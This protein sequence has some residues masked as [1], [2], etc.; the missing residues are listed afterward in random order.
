MSSY[1]RLTR[2]KIHTRRYLRLLLLLLRRR[3]ELWYHVMVL[4]KLGDPL[5]LT[6]RNGLSFAC[7]NRGFTRSKTSGSSIYGV[8]TFPIVALRAILHNW[9]I[10]ACNTILQYKSSSNMMI[11]GLVSV[12]VGRNAAQLLRRQPRWASTSEES[13]EYEVSPPLSEELC[14]NANA[15]GKSACVNDLLGRPSSIRDAGGSY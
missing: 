13:T 14:E 10:A 7:S 8:K 1:I 3:R 12:A 6:C 11:L 9:N 15:C 5:W 4:K 2:V